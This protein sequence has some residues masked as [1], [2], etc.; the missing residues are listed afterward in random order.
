MGHIM[1]LVV[2]AAEGTASACFTWQLGALSPGSVISIRLFS[3]FTQSPYN[4]AGSVV[5]AG[6]Q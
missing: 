6:T 1:P 5:R 2:R 4:G 3:G